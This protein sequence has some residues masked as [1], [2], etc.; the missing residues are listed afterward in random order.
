MNI[1]NRLC[2]RRF[3]SVVKFIAQRGL[4]FGG[5]ENVG[6][7]RKFFQKIF[8]TFIKEILKKDDTMLLATGLQQFHKSLIIVKYHVV[9]S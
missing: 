2:L 4:A 8:K 5:D 9:A 7:P 1:G 3:V 6:S